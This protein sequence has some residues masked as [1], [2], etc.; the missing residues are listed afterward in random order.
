MYQW[1]LFGEIFHRCL[2]SDV[3]EARI[4]PAVKVLL[5]QKI[6][7]PYYLSSS[8]LDFAVSVDGVLYV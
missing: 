2:A 6:T 3:S 1:N 8:G 5:L 7:R 4:S